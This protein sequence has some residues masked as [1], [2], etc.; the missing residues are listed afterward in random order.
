VLNC[1]KSSVDSRDCFVTVHIL[2]VYVIG[3]R[4]SSKADEQSAEMTVSKSGTLKVQCVPYFTVVVIGNQ[5]RTD[6][7]RCLSEQ[8]YIHRVLMLLV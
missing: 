8:C 6:L 2:C 1:D 4:D 7:L 3:H 5:S